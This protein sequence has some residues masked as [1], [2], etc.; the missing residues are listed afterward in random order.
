MVSTED[1]QVITGAKTFTAPTT[2]SGGIAG[3]TTAVSGAVT[4]GTT[5]GVTG[6]STLSGGVTTTTLAASG[7]VTGSNIPAGTIDS[8]TGTTNTLSKF[9]NGAAGVQGNSS[10]TDDGTQVSTLENVGI[11][12]AVPSANLHVSTSLTNVQRGII[13]EQTSNDANGSFVYLQKSRSGGAVIN[14]DPIGSFSALGNDGTVFQPAARVKFTVDGAVSAGVVPMSIGFFTG[15]AGSGTERVHISSAG[16]IGMLNNVVFNSASQGSG[17]ALTIGGTSATTGGISVFDGASGS[18]SEMLAVYPADGAAAATRVLAISGRALSAGF[19]SGAQNWGITNAGV[20]TGA[21]IDTASAANVIKINGTSLT[22]VTGSGS[23]VLATSP[24]VTGPVINTSVGCGTGHKAGSVSTGSLPSVSRT[25]VT[26]TWCGSAFA[27]TSYIPV[28]SVSEGSSGTGLSLRIEH[29]DTLN[30][31]SIRVVVLNDAAG[32]LTG[33][34][35]CTADH[36]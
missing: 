34:L 20:V 9:T 7:A 23:A 36:P 11:G 13:S 30:T 16:T 19:L 2:L 26:L 27:D 28:C 5:L 35:L 21:T 32:A 25:F 29:I 15:T 3:T 4:V 17:A 8:G 14:G 6:V 24:I 33:T 1:T 12:V 18:Q 10:V 31:G 22:A